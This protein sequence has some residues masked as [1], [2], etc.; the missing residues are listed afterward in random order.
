MIIWLASYPKNGNTWLRTLISAYY[1]TKDGLF[2]GD[3]QLNHI[4][5][6]PV[7]KY[8]EGFNYN[9]NLPGDTSRFWIAAQE[10]INKDKEIKFFKTHN[11]LVKL[12]QNNFTDKK[13]TLGCIYIVRDPRNV[14]NSMS[15]HFQLDND[16]TLNVMLDENNFTY[17]FKKKKILVII[18]LLAHGKKIISRGKTI[19]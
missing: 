13:N 5:Q 19:I 1:Y 17:D 12:G 9:L 4:P 6:F 2:L 11:A 16:N 15:T 10:R 7:K 18:N 3:Q 8:F 14:L